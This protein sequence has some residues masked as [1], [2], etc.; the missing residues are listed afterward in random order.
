MPYE[1]ATRHRQEQGFTIVELMV[2]LVVSLLASIGIYAIFNQS[3]AQQV[4]SSDTQE[5]W[6]QARIAMA[7]IER[8]VRMAG[9]GYSNNPACTVNAYNASRTPP[10]F[11]FSMQPILSDDPAPSSANTSD[12]ITVL[13]SSSDYGGLPANKLRSDMPDSSA[14]LNI[15]STQGFREGDMILLQEP[16]KSCTLLQVTEVQDSALK[17]Q[18]N[19]GGSAPYNP[20]GGHNIFPSGG[21]TAANGVNIYNMGSMINHQY[22]ISTTSEISGQ[23]DSAPNL[24]V[25][26]LSTRAST[27]IARGISS[28]QVL[29]GLDSNGD[30]E[31]D[32]YGRPGGAGWFTTNASRIRTAR[33]ALLARTT[34]P[35]RSYTSPAQIT[36]LP[37]IGGNAAVI[38]DVPA[39]DTHF[40]YQVF[41]TEI[42]LRNPILANQ[43]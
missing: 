30:D 32:S 39:T 1:H 6:Q 42:P 43:P 31:V 5:L 35:D 20:P 15:S 21:Y 28:L 11:T 9:Y 3:S 40:R 29:Y 27:P 23:T 2:A 24:I 34:M 18:H 10:D 37:A 17:L 36:V 25:E 38:Y 4:R 13:Y 8:D 14:E 19:P 41:Q 26:D 22:R 33:I 16:G 7:M 12:Q